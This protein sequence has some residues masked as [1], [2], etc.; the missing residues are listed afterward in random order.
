MINTVLEKSA[1]A[2]SIAAMMSGYAYAA[3]NLEITTATD[4]NTE[5]I[6]QAG[7]VVVTKFQAHDKNATNSG[8]IRGYDSF[9]LQDWSKITN[10]GTID[11]GDYLTV[12]N[13]KSARIVNTAE[14]VVVTHKDT[15]GVI[16]ENS[17]TVTAKTGKLS[18]NGLVLHEGGRFQQENG[19]SLTE[20]KLPLDPAHT[21]P[22]IQIDAG[23]L[24]EA[25]NIHLHSGVVGTILN[26]AI[27]GDTIRIEG[28]YMNLSST[29]SIEGRD[30]SITQVDQVNAHLSGGRVAAS[31]KLTFTSYMN[32]DGMVV[33]T[34]VLTHKAAV[35]IRGNSKFTNL[36]ELNLGSTLSIYTDS[37]VF[38]NGFIRTVTNRGSN[39]QTRIQLMGE[40]TDISIGEMIVEKHAGQNTRLVDKTS[41]AETGRTSFDIRQLT[42]EEGATLDIY[43]DDK[44]ASASAT[45]VVVREMSLAKDSLVRFGFRDGTFDPMAGGEIDHV[46]L[47]ENA[48]LLGAPIVPEPQPEPLML[49][50]AAPMAASGGMTARINKI[51]IGGNNAQVNVPTVGDKMVVEVKENVSGAQI[52][53]IRTKEVELHIE[54]TSGTQEQP[55]ITVGKVDDDTSVQLVGGSGN[56]TGNSKEDLEKVAASV[57]LGETKK[58]VTVRQEANDIFDSASAEVTESG[59]IGNVVVKANENTHGISEMTSVGLHIWRNEINDMNKR[60]GELRDSKAHQAG[61]WT[62]VYNGKAS[63]G[64]QNITNKY[65]AF[66]FGYDRQLWDKTWLGAALGWTDGENDFANGGGDSELYSLTLYASKLWD[67]GAFIDV[68]GKYGRLSNEYDITVGGQKSTA[69][70]DADALSFSAEA[71]WRIYPIDNAF[72]IEPQVELMYGRVEAVDYTTSTGVA[73]NQDKSESLVGRAGFAVG[74]ALP[75]N[76]GNVYLRASVLHDWEGDASFS[77]TKNGQVRPLSEDLGGTWYEYGMGMNFN[78]TDNV[79][80]YGDLEA[81]ADGEVKTDYRVNL[82]V[83]YSF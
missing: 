63:F 19:Q 74:Y 15:M 60:L 14:G 49:M 48:K 46:I 70:Y 3:N 33:D 29:G 55:A 47:N 58:P 21:T 10:S 1:I 64:A 31:E 22:T 8:T 2:V 81:S 13:A 16:I 23:A 50:S 41:S 28:S 54:K 67:N 36:T 80:L 32:L 12:D 72:F 61:V 37:E 39:G 20:I 7:D 17:G 24:L 30:V 4:L 75:K 76:Q 82:G 78:A 9:T 26:G 83:R 38:D 62:R 52:E 5:H 79:H 25:D 59:G 73:V 18:A 34:P 27:K 69:D 57:Q 56:N 44:A 65:T 68:T 71:G 77:F 66:Q 35:N 53:E 45:K 42:L 43:A 40:K 11:V 51:T 6:G